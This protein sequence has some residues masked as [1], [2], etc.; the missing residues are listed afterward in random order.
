M[1]GRIRAKA[2]LPVIPKAGFHV[3]IA[4]V[5]KAVPVFQ[6]ASV[7]RIK[8]ERIDNLVKLVFEFLRFQIAYVIVPRGEK[9][10]TVAAHVSPQVSDAAGL[11]LDL[12]ALGGSSN[13]AP[14]A[15]FL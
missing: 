9:A 8:P 12:G 2:P 6:D 1:V 11:S 4:V 14:A 3:P 15:S 5:G 10:F 13:A 7:G